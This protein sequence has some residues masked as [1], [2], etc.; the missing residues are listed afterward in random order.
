MSYTCAFDEYH[1]STLTG[2][3]TCRD[4]IRKCYLYKTGIYAKKVSSSESSQGLENNFHLIELGLPWTLIFREREHA[5]YLYLEQYGYN[6][7]NIL[8]GEKNN[9]ALKFGG[10]LLTKIFFRSFIWLQAW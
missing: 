4:K 1:I 8:H 2:Y 6:W 7:N 5:N 9:N 10:I 3:Q